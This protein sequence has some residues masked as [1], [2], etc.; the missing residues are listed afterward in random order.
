MSS[1]FTT[2]N[3]CFSS[4]RTK[5]GPQKTLSG[6]LKMNMLGGFYLFNPPNSSK[7]IL[8]VAPPQSPGRCV[9]SVITLYPLSCEHSSQLY[10]EQAV[11]VPAANSPGIQ[12]L[13]PTRGSSLPRTGLCL[14]PVNL[15]QGKIAKTFIHVCPW[16]YFLIFSPTPMLLSLFISNDMP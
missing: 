14:L 13:P 16:L 9:Y 11:Y 1:Y 15:F 6:W 5:H 4:P 7:A 3:Y 12:L 10:T 2:R 8:F